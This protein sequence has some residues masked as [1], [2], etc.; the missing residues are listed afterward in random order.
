MVAAVGAFGGVV[1]RTAAQGAGTAAIA[2]GVGGAARGTTIAS[3]VSGAVGNTVS[4]ARSGKSSIL[5]S[6]GNPIITPARSGITPTSGAAALEQNR[7]KDGL[8]E[9][10]INLLQTIAENTSGKNADAKAKPQQTLAESVMATLGSMAGGLTAMVA[11]FGL[12]KGFKDAAAARERGESEFGIF[13]EFAKGTIKGILNIPFNILDNILNI[14]DIDIPDN[15]GDLIVEGAIKMV[16]D[17]ADYIK[18]LPDRIIKA[19][20]GMIENIGI[21]EF[22]ILGRS[23]GPYYPFRGDGEVPQE[24]TQGSPTTSKQIMP[25]AKNKEGISDDLNLKE[26]SPTVPVTTSSN[27][28]TK[29]PFDEAEYKK[30]EGTTSYIKDPVSGE[31]VTIKKAAKEMT[32]EQAMEVLGKGENQGRVRGLNEEILKSFRNGMPMPNV[33]ELEQMKIVSEDGSPQMNMFKDAV[34]KVYPELIKKLYD[35]ETKDGKNASDLLKDLNDPTS[36]ATMASPDSFNDAYRISNENFKS[37]FSP[38]VALEQQKW[39]RGPKGFEKVNSLATPQSD[40]STTKSDSGNAIMDSS[41]AAEAAKSKDSSNVVINAPSS[42]VNA[43]KSSNMVMPENI[44]NNEPS[45]SRYVDG[46][47]GVNI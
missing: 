26:F 42:T 45:M 13:A 4:Q 1:A 40:L 37:V 22:K 29:K 28:A 33:S 30:L 12:F 10:M 41:A 2:K 7:E 14:F 35:S 32:K 46:L 8:N 3:S 5:D 16:K 17:L 31:G 15:M 43:P 19:I 47:S 34:L 25:E 38:M 24:D 44:R 21:P 20:T 39:K 23:F 27:K 36:E 6:R 9:R 11:G 18:N